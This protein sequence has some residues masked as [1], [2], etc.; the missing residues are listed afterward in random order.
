LNHL[1]AIHFR[2]S[3]RPQMSRYLTKL[4]MS[5]NRASENLCHQ[6]APV[7]EEAPPAVAQVVSEA[8]QHAREV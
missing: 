8:D 5:K 2:T 7:E 4:P 3:S 6:V 1:L